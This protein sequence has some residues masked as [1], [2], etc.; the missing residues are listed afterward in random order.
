MPSAGSSQGKKGDLTR[1]VRLGASGGEYLVFTTAL[2]GNM[3][4]ALVFEIETPF[5]QIRS[6]AY[7]IARQLISPP[8]EHQKTED[9]TVVHPR[10]APGSARRATEKGGAGTPQVKPLLEDIPS[11]MPEG[12]FSRLA[13]MQEV[14]LPQQQ[15]LVQPD[16]LHSLPSEKLLAGGVMLAMQEFNATPIVHDLSYFC[17]LI[18]R[19]PHHQLIGDLAEK[20]AE[21]VGQL[22]MAYGW[23]LEHLSISP[24]KLQWIVFTVPSVPPADMV[25]TLRQQTSERIFE[26][27]AKIRQENPSGD[28][29]A[30]GY[31]IMTEITAVTDSVIQDFIQK[32]RHYQGAAPKDSSRL[33]R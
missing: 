12:G 9:M 21:W 11:P 1:F 6:L 15:G 10:S 22:C 17:L 31:L 18:P 33:R 2:R 32:I 28:F 8:D 19:M 5:A 30:P 27:F 3:V 14:E 29:W 25:E 13:T 26:H 4:L 7:E 16:P 23:R 20:L 24:E